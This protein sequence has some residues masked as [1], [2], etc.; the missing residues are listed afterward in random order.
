MSG[1]RDSHRLA[2][3]GEIGPFLEEARERQGLSLKEVEQSTKIRCRYLEGLESENPSELPGKSY[4]QG[5]LRSYAEFLDLDVE[6][7]SQRFKRHSRERRQRRTRREDSHRLSAGDISPGEEGASPRPLRRRPGGGALATLSFA[8]LILAVIAAALYLLRGDVISSDSSLFGQEEPLSDNVVPVE[9]GVEKAPQAG[10]GPE[11]T[12]EEDEAGKPGRE[13]SLRA[14][15]LVQGAESWLSIESDAGV[16]YA[17]IAQPGFS[18]TFKPGASFRIT[19]GNAGAVELQ[20][21]GIDYGT[22]GADG[23]VTSKSFTFKTKR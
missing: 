15:V 18:R 1:H 8:L 9:K 21:N 5:F 2:W 22:L 4:I 23:E 12:L 14:T 7:L 16:E 11:P 20:I 10:G 13:S 17:G 6:E 3:N 19:T